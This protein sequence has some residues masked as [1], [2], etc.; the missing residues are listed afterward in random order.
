VME[1]TEY[2]SPPPPEEVGVGKGDAGS[3]CRAAGE[4]IRGKKSNGDR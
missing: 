3:W 2:G 1:I 4:K